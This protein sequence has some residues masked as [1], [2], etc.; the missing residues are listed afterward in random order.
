MRRPIAAWLGLGIGA[1]ALVLLIAALVAGPRSDGPSTPEL[2]AFERAAGPIVKQ[3]GEVVELGLKV[4]IQDLSTDHEL[5]P[6]V[7][8]D[9]ANAWEK[10]LRQQRDRF[11]KIAAP[12]SLRRARA[13]FVAAFGE[14]ARVAATIHLAALAREGEREKLL[15]LAIKRGEHA[16]ATFDAASKQVQGLRKTHGMSPDPNLP[17]GSKESKKS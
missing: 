6:A 2:A 13:Q 4:G 1:G 5:A 11:A 14:Y 17:Q 3:G 16:D 8:A 9:Q 12:G 7:V 10:D 15:D